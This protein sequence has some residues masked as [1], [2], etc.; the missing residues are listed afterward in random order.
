MKK[1]IFSLVLFPLIAVANQINEISK[2]VVFVANESNPF[3]LYYGA[4]PGYYGYFRSIYDYFWPTEHS[5]GSGFIISPDGHVITNAHVVENCTKVLV[6]M[7]TDEMKVCRAKVLGKDLRTDLAVLKLETDGDF[8]LPFVSLGD[9]N[10]LQAGDSVICIGSPLVDRLECTVTAGVISATDRNNFGDMIEGYIQT[11]VAINNGNSGGPIFNSKGEVIGVCCWTLR[12]IGIEGLHFAIPSNV[13]KQISRQIIANGKISQGFLGVHLEGNNE[14]IFDT[15]FFDRH[16]GAR[17]KT[18]F[19]N[20]PAEKA[21]L[22]GGDLIIGLNGQLVR[23]SQNFRNQLAILDAETTVELS[24]E[25]DGKILEISATLGSD[26]MS[27]RYSYLRGPSI[28]L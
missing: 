10:E 27:E 20:S 14:M 4:D 25:R 24:I 12:G 26:E 23:S 15:Y 16:E 6:V 18:I 13:A 2:S 5:H 22:K 8:P 1:F 19:K 7:R 11:D 9:S 3:E 17:I 28:V 21:G